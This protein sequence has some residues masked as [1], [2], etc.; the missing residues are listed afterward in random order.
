LLKVLIVDDTLTNRVLAATILEKRGHFVKTAENGA[1]A[2]EHLVKEDFDLVLMDVQ[3]PV[4]SGIEAA[5]I[6]RSS[7]SPVRRHDVP[8]F[9][10]TAY[11]VGDGKRQCLNAGMNGF[12]TKPLKSDELIEIIERYALEAEL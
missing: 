3:M 4:M 11:A 5:R 10:V 12:L 6:I 1:A 9:A 7:A 2:I 8:I